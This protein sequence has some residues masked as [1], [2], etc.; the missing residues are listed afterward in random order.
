M[1]AAG[2]RVASRPDRPDAAA[3]PAD[4]VDD[5]RQRL[6]DHGPAA[7]QLRR[8]RLNSSGASSWGR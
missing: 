7:S 5:L 6:P 1:T 4:G 8:T 2:T 3:L